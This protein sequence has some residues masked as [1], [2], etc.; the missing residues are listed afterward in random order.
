MITNSVSVNARTS[1]ISFKILTAI[2][3]AL[4]ICSVTVTTFAAT[5]DYEVIVTDGEKSVSI[6][7]K[8]NNPLELVRQAGSVQPIILTFP[9]LMRERA[10]K[11]LSREQTS[12]ELRITA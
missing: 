3:T 11:L 10:E 1:K 6:S 5:N 2:I 9:R 7:A 12:S 4:F 8:S